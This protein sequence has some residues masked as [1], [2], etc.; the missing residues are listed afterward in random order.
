MRS[1]EYMLT[2]FMGASFISNS[3]ALLAPPALYISHTLL[4][5]RPSTKLGSAIISRPQ[6]NS[7]TVMRR[8]RTECGTISP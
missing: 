7:G 8:P 1:V 6:T 5:S 3:P 4:N 2:V